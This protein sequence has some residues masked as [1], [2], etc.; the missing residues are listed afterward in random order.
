MEPLFVSYTFDDPS[1]GMDYGSYVLDVAELPFSHQILDEVK[2]KIE[3]ECSVSNAWILNYDLL[4][5]EDHPSRDGVYGYVMGYQFKITDGRSGH[6]M[7]TLLFEAPL[8]TL[9]D[10]RN[11]EEMVRS[12]IK[13]RE[14]H[15]VSVKPMILTESEVL[16][17]RGL[18]VS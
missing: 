7:R 3:G 15:L 9:A 17:A 14:V 4:L 18:S 5:G 16:Q 12:G 11:A 10:I 1:L 13:V 8:L 2:L 6:G